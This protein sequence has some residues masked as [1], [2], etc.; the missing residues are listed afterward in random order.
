MSYQAAPTYDQPIVVKG[1][2]SS[3]WYRFLIS[4]LYQGTP[5]GSEITLTLTGSPFVYTAPNKGFVLL[6]NGTVS[7]VT[8][9]RLG[10]YTLPTSGVLPVS[11]NDILT[12]TYSVAPNMVFF[13]Q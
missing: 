5:P 11:K 13:P 10:T 6:S 1:V 8:I 3:A 12:V 2:T 9:T 7:A 4:G